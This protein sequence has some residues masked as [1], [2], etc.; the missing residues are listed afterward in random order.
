MGT[1]TIIGTYETRVKT[2]AHNQLTSRIVN[3][4]FGSI[5]MSIRSGTSELLLR[6]TAPALIT[7]K[8]H[9]SLNVVE[10]VSFQSA[11]TKVAIVQLLIHDHY[12]R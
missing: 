7:L 10:H 5:E 12:Q 6:P 11:N 2:E 8:E 3:K 4:V 9:G 1:A